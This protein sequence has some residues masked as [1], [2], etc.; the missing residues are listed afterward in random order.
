MDDGDRVVATVKAF[1]AMFMT[2]LRGLDQSVPSLLNEETLPELETSLECA[3]L[4]FVEGND[5]EEPYNKAIRAYGRKLFGE[6]TEEERKKIWAVRYDAFYEFLCNLSEE[7]RKKR[8][9]TLASEEEEKKMQEQ[10]E[11]KK[12]QQE[13]EK[14][15]AEP[16]E[17]AED[18]D[19]E[20]WYGDA[21]IKDI[22]TNPRCFR[23]SP[24]W[25]EYK[26]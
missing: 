9:V 25:K 18:E 1:G 26:E 2:T 17:D 14:G 5:W 8:N 11:K 12:A 10:A 22:D 6:R 16:E 20:P 19:D 23:V 13:K 15:K 4:V 7:E 24:T 3:A 21:N